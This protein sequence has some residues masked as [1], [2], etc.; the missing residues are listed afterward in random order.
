MAQSPLHWCWRKDPH[1]LKTSRKGARCHFSPRKQ[2]PT[3]EQKVSLGI[4]L[5][6]SR[7]EFNELNSRHEES[8]K[9]LDS[10]LVPSEV[11]LLLPAKKSLIHAVARIGSGLTFLFSGT[12]TRTWIG[13]PPEVWKP[14][15]A[16]KRRAQAKSPELGSFC[17]DSSGFLLLTVSAPSSVIDGTLRT[18]GGRSLSRCVRVPK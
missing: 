1:R 17:Q 4:L 14:S 7:T 3:C 2:I 15:S 13:G 18:R 11:V 12:R 5:W 10:S 8:G 16:E 9:S 6:T